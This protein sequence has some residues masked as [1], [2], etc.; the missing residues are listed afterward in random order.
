M[1]NTTHKSRP[2]QEVS[3]SIAAPGRDGG[4]ANVGYLAA[5]F[6]R[7]LDNTQLN[8][9]GVLQIANMGREAIEGASFTKTMVRNAW[10]TVQRHERYK[11]SLGGLERLYEIAM[12]G[13]G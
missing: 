5:G 2:W 10:R 11:E 6:M 7:V 4:K 8:H 1:V 13:L 9:D 3:Y 12:K